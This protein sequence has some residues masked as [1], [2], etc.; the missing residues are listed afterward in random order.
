M[1]LLLIGTGL[2]LAVTP[3][4]VE[5]QPGTLNHLRWGYGPVR[6]GLCLLRRCQKIKFTFTNFADEWYSS[7]AG[8]SHAGG[9]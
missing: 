6:Y 7:I 9:Y 8:G 4:A 2:A 5:D 1:G 3:F